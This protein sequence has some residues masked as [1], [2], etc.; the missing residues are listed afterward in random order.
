MAAIEIVTAIPGA[1]RPGKEG[2]AKEP[3]NPA[4]TAGR[5]ARIATIAIMVE[6]N[7]AAR[8]VVPT[9]PARM[10]R[11]PMDP[12]L[13]DPARKRRVPTA[14][15]A[16]PVA[17]ASGRMQPRAMRAAMVARHRVR[18]SLASVPAASELGS[19]EAVGGGVAGADAV[20]AAA[21]TPATDN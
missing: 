9:D 11:V 16:I 10:D 21:R 4:A 14:R 17:A 6:E 18:V 13:T 20:M 3:A 7:I 5:A 12:A 1:R 19:A 15:A 8:R 2:L